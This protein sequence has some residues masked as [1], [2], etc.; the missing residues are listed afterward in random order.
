MARG[1]D[2]E[3]FQEEKEATCYGVESGVLDPQV[4]FICQRGF[5]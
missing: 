1:Q 3:S 4:G 2:R 5:V